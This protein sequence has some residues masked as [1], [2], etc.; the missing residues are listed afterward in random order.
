MTD[1]AAANFELL[2]LLR[3]AL[4]GARIIHCRRNPID[5]CLSIFFTNFGGR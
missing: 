1:K 2:G 3:L 5:T 4:P